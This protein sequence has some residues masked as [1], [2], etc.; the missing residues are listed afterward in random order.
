MQQTLDTTA[1]IDA[2]MTKTAYYFIDQH[3][4][5]I[6]EDMTIHFWSLFY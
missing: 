3:P 4:I 2:D 6:K 5:E 1:S